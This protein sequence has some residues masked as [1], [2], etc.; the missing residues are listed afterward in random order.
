[1]IEQTTNQLQPYPDWKTYE[2]D[3]AYNDDLFCEDDELIS[4]L[5]YIIDHHLSVGEKSIFLIHTHNG[6]NYHK[7][8]RI[9]GCSVTT[10]RNRVIQIR[11]KILSYLDDNTIV[12]HC[13]HNNLHD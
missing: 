2:E 6:S 3:F 13:H 10:A 8:S 9:L 5:K 12:N 4:R 7:T 11:N 1:M